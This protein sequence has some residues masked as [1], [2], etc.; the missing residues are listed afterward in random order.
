MPRYRILI[1]SG[2]QSC[3]VDHDAIDGDTRGEALLERIAA[4]GRVALGAPRE[5]DRRRGARQAKIAAAHRH[6]REAMRLLDEL[7]ALPSARRLARSVG[8]AFRR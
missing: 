2:A 4:A 7:R 8:A 1:W 5:T 3:L 6:L